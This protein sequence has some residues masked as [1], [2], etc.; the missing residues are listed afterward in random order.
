MDAHVKKAK[1]LRRLEHRERDGRGAH[2][3]RDR[4]AGRAPRCACSRSSAE[5]QQET[6]SALDTYEKLAKLLPQ[7]KDGQR[8][9]WSG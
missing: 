4:P 8:R 6:Q 3:G 1:S 7:D 9:P 2:R 5:R